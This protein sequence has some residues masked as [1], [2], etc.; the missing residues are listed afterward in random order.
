[1]IEWTDAT[2][3]PGQGC[4]KVDGDCKFCYMF[5]DKERYG[6]DP[7]KVVRS[8]PGTFD[9]I[10]NPAKYPP[11]ALVFTASWSDWW[12]PDFDAMRPDAFE[13]VDRRRDLTFQVLTKRP[14]R[15]AGTLPATWGADGWP[16]VWLGTSIGSPKGAERAK[17]LADLPA[18]V[19]F[20][21]IEPLWSPGVA[22]AIADVVLAGRIDWL[23]LGGE[24]GPKARP[25]H[26]EWAREVIKLAQQAGVPLLFKQWGEWLP[27]CEVKPEIEPSLYRSNRQAKPGEDQAELDDAF[28]R[29]CR[30]PHQVLRYD[31]V[32]RELRDPLAYRSDVPG[33][34]AMLAFKIGKHLA[35]RTCDG[36][37]H[38]GYPTPRTGRRTPMLGRVGR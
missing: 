9:A 2:W 37:V 19:R 30:V 5:R 25:M 20:L 29:T 27:V 31:G 22:D 21:S 26:P 12:H 1:M 36:V 38:H 10:L 35:G 33:W 6:Q 13:R 28:G 3:N 4:T 11:G 14:E 8:K 32:H 7:T 23:I 18:V 34:P 24:S 17:V 15:I 16:H